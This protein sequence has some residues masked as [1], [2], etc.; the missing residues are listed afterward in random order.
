MTTI[1]QTYEQPTT[2]ILQTEHLMQNNMGVN[3]SDEVDGDEEDEV[4]SKEH[5]YLDD[6]ILPLQENI[7]GEEDE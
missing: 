1:K 4:L 3:W 5:N 7:W 6:I 2:Q